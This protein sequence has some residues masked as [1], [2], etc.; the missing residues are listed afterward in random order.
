VKENNIEQT[1]AGGQIQWYKLC[2]AIIWKFTK[3]WNAK[4]DSTCT[5]F[6]TLSNQTSQFA[7]VN[8]KSIVKYMAHSSAMAS[9]CKASKARG[10]YLEAGSITHPLSSLMVTPQPIDLLTVSSEPSTLYAT[11]SNFPWPDHCSQSLKFAWVDWRELTTTVCFRGS[12]CSWLSHPT[13][14]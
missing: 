12:T 11:S 4:D 8:D 9:L 7:C 6:Q 14:F 1:K 5:N 10:V 2:H 13:L 3:N